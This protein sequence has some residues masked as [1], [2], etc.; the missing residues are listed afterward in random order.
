MLSIILLTSSKTGLLH[1]LKI[2]ILCSCICSIFK[3]RRLII[4]SFSASRNRIRGPACLRSTARGVLLSREDRRG[5]RAWRLSSPQD[6]DRG[7][8]ENKLLQAH[9][10]F[11]EGT[12]AV[13]VCSRVREGERSDACKCVVGTINTAWSLETLIHRLLSQF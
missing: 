12:G 1:K 10:V 4:A 8:E 6:V 3:P 5:W 9:K 7:E 13:C 2:V 11:A